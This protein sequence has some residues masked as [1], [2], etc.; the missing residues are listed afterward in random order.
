MEFD[1][2]ALLSVVAEF[3]PVEGVPEMVVYDN[4]FEQADL[5]TIDEPLRQILLARRG[6]IESCDGVITRSLG[7]SGII[8]TPYGKVLWHTRRVICR[9]G[10]LP[11]IEGPRTRE[12]RSFNGGQATHMRLIQGRRIYTLGAFYR[13][14]SGLPSYVDATCLV[15]RNQDRDPHKVILPE[16]MCASGNFDVKRPLSAEEMERYR[17]MA[18]TCL[19]QE[20]VWVPAQP[21]SQ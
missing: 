16:G 6:T 8:M 15:W 12:W 9:G 14:P 3:L 13:R 20:T 17:A 18:Q 5:G 2:R 7:D 4:L 21:M 1:L 11:A 10:D 19:S